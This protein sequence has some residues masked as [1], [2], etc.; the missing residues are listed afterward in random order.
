[1]ITILRRDVIAAIAGSALALIAVAGTNTAPMGSAIFDW[2]TIEAKPTKAGSV[3]R[4]FQAPTTNLGELA[5][6]VTTLKP[7]EAPH[8]AHKHPE[9]ELIVVKEGTV[10]C[11]VNGQ[12]R[13]VGSGSVIF[14][15]SEQMHDI[16]NAGKTEASYY[17]I[18]W[19]PL[20]KR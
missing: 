19:K 2:N 7:G 5:C 20:T 17:V 4:F 15:A 8:G 13:Q 10:E 16:R 6:H 11:L 12:T 14:H 18:K 3:R 1:M 9:E